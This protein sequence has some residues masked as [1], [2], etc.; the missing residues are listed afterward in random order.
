MVMFMKKE[1][2]VHIFVFNNILHRVH[3]LIKVK[4]VAL[5]GK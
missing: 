2:G 3:A 4:G 1:F 5:L